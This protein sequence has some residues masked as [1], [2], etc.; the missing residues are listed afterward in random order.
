[1]SLGR[2]IILVICIIVF[3]GAAGTLLNYFLTGMREQ[4][5]LED[6]AKLKTQREDM[7][8]DKGNR[9]VRRSLSQKRRYNRLDTDGRHKDRL[10][11]HVDA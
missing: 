7:E 1:M 9:K 11:G 4:Q 10:S 2:K 3:L 8:T 5:A 6:L